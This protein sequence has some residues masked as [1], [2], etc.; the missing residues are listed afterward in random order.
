MLRVC[1]DLLFLD[2]R[3]VRL[4][5]HLHLH[6]VTVL[7]PRKNNYGTRKKQQQK[8]KISKCILSMHFRKHKSKKL[9]RFFVKFGL[10]HALKVTL[11]NCQSSNYKRK[12]V[13]ILLYE[14]TK[15]FMRQIRILISRFFL[16]SN[17]PYF[18]WTVY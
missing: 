13:Y 10:W 17:I 14:N 4:K 16:C 5:P 7:Y 18:L 9:I 11:L 1:F 12:L 8:T 6:F 3:N 15:L 2:F